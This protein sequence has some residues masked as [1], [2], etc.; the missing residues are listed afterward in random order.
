MGLGRPF[1][2]DPDF[3]RRLLAEAA[4]DEPVPRARLGFGQRLP[5][6]LRESLPVRLVNA[7][8]EAA[9]YYRQ[10]LALARDEDP[11]PRLGLL[12]ALRRHYRD[13]LRILRRRHA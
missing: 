4:G 6:W 1:A 3:P 11:D 12:T 8:G 9:W 7:Q 10:I 13:E 2:I 5:R